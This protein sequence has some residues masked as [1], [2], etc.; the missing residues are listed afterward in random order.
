VRFV[1]FVSVSVDL[2]M[3]RLML[4]I[5]EFLAL[6]PCDQTK[7]LYSHLGCQKKTGPAKML[8][9][10]TGR[11][12]KRFGDQVGQLAEKQAEQNEPPSLLH[13]ELRAS[14]GWLCSWRPNVILFTSMQ[15]QGSLPGPSRAIEKRKIKLKLE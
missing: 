1:N 14:L 10:S 8:W 9:G 15:A 7:T 13:R 11:S 12:A 5:Q 2:C 6:V 4:L 3:V